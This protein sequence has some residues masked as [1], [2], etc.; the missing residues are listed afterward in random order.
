MDFEYSPKVKALQ[1]R[2][3]AFMDSHVYPNQKRY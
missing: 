2:V 3:G 1:K